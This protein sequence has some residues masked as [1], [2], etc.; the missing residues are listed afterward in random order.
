MTL[1]TGRQL[2]IISFYHAAAVCRL[3]NLHVL[4]CIVFFSRVPAVLLLEKGHLICVCFIGVVQSLDCPVA[5]EFIFGYVS[6]F[7]AKC[8]YYRLA[9]CKWGPCCHYF[10][11]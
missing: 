2:L 7:I 3:A 1:P 11:K 6:A 4:C 5:C 10:A 9:L 8:V